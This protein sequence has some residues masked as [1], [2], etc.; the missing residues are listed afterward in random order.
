MQDISGFKAQRRNFVVV[1]IG[2]SFFYYVDASVN[3]VTI[4][5]VHVDFGNPEAF[6]YSAWIIWA[7]AFIRYLQYFFREGVAG[8]ASDY[9]EQKRRVVVP[10]I[11]LLSTYQ[12]SLLP[13]DDYIRRSKIRFSSA[14][15]QRSDWRY[16]RATAFF[17]LTR[18][19]RPK[20]DK[21]GSSIKSTPLQGINFIRPR[22]LKVDLL[23]PLRFLGSLLGS[24]I[25]G[26]ILVYQPSGSQTRDGFHRSEFEVGLTLICWLY[27]KS[28]YRLFVVDISFFEYLAPFFIG[29]VPIFL[30]LWPT[31]FE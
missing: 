20:R 19:K 4:G 25:T 17:R 6:I 29:L 21:Q 31:T 13:Q 2:I 7:Y 30:A 27:I 12:Y 22:R 3:R 8:L 14:I 15:R 23:F 28:L 18:R 1:S 10:H 16:S 26:L 11:S 24:R 5:G 9:N